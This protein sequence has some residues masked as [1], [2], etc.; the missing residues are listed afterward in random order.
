MRNGDGLQTAHRL[1]HLDNGLVQRRQTI[2]QD[3]A[4]GSPDEKRPLTNGELRLNADGEQS[5]LLPLD[6]VAMADSQLVKGRPLLACRLHVLPV[7]LA[8]RTASRRS[9]ALGILST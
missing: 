4:G 1:D 7:V 2:P 9:I 5:R 6:R 3:V 8:N